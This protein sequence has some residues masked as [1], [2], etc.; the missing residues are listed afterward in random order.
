MLDYQ[1]ITNLYTRIHRR[2]WKIL[3]SSNFKSFGKNSRI[4][5]PMKINRAKYIEI[6]DYV[7]IHDKAWLDALEVNGTP[8]LIIEDYTRIGHFSV[9]SSMRYVRVGKNVL[10]ADNVYVSDN[11]HGYEDITIPIMDQPIV[12][13]SSVY[14]GDNSWVGQNVSIIGA[15]IGKHCVIGA[16]SVVTSDIPDYC[17]AVGSPARVIKRYNFKTNEWQKTAKNGEFD[18]GETNQQGAT[19][20]IVLGDSPWDC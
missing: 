19:P 17:V 9:I 13:K 11:L 10:I 1:S 4:M 7:S 2:I 3:F 16:N 8:R 14:I 6:G 5:F 12:F 18:E 15:K 20:R